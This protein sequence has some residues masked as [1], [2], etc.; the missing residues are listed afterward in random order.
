MKAE[1][2]IVIGAYPNGRRMTGNGLIEHSAD[3]RTVDEFAANT[4]ADDAAGEH[5][6]D[7]NDPMA[8]QQDRLA[9]K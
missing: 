3:S 4:E 7:H 5:I 2:R 6:D 9:T 1:Q 8:T